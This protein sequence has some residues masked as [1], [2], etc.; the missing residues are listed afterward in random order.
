M[1]RR[2]VNVEMKEDGGGGRNGGQRL[3]REGCVSIGVIVWESLG[4]YIEV[5]IEEKGKEGRVGVKYGNG[6]D[7]WIVWDQ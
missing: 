1:G 3:E 6:Q 4:I 5:G 7:L 2:W